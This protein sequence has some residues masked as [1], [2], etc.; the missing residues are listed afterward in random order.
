MWGPCIWRFRLVRIHSFFLSFAI[1][2]S[3]RPLYWRSFNTGSKI[4][5]ISICSAPCRRQKTASNLL[6][7]QSGAFGIDSPTPPQGEGSTQIFIINEKWLTEHLFSGEEIDPKKIRW[8]REDFSPHTYQIFPQKK[9]RVS[10]VPLGHQL[11]S[12]M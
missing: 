1:H 2:R 9:K 4:T 8:A 6:V 12:T 11:H 7:T 10:F 5:K 3:K